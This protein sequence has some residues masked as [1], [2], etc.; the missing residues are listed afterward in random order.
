MSHKKILSLCLILAMLL[1]TACTSESIS[2]GIDVMLGRK[3]VQDETSYLS[4]Q[5]LIE[6]QALIYDATFDH[7]GYYYDQMNNED[8]TVYQVIYQ[9]LVAQEDT[10][11]LVN[12]R[13]A[14]ASLAYKYIIFDHPE[15]YYVDGFQLERYPDS[16][17]VTFRPNYIK[18][19]EQ[20]TMIDAQLQ[21][22]SDHLFDSI[23]QSSE[24]STVR[25]I[26]DYII[27][28]TFY[29]LSAPDLSNICSV[30]MNNHAV[31]EGYAK[32]M[33]YFCQKANIECIVV[34]GYIR[35]SGTAHLWNAVKLD[36]QWYFVDVTWG[37]EDFENEK[38]APEVRYDYLC[39][40]TAQIQGTHQVEDGVTIPECI[41]NDMNYYY[42]TGQ[43]IYDAG[44]GTFKTIFKS[45]SNTRTVAFACADAEI[46]QK[47][48]THLI[49]EKHIFDYLPSKK[50]H[51][52]YVTNNN[53]WSMT[54][55]IIDE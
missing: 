14:Q 17:D 38:R 50:M 54:F 20:Q 37:D 4:S 42:Q 22:Y 41:S 11:D 48:V 9:S 5:P 36:G 47:T 18:T 19:I 52:K 39:V 34:P 26:Y 2:N 31:C 32:A 1:L 29:D 24:F 7:G 25:G 13:D 33:M 43:V 44:S 8:K 27:T 46:Y 16:T 55:W 49:D 28:N 45:L 23:D 53:V 15:L 40:S 6:P 3:Q 35:T 30:I 51:I 12:T 21:V 10:C